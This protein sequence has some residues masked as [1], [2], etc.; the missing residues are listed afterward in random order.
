MMSATRKRFYSTTEAAHH[1]G[2]AGWQVQRL[3]QRGE[4]KEA[5]KVDRRRII[6]RS[7]FPEIKKALK[8]NGWL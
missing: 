8:A 2:V 4:V 6:E 5:E 3:Y 7:Q 1:F